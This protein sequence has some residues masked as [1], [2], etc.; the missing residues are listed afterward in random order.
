M[1]NFWSSQKWI[2]LMRCIQQATS[3]L[4]IIALVVMPQAREFPRNLVIMTA[5]AANIAVRSYRS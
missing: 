2:N 3:V 1:G 5:I 4:L